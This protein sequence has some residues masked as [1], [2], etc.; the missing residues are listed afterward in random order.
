MTMH[1]E[2]GVNHS[3]HLKVYSDATFRSQV[4]PDGIYEFA[5]PQFVD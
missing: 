1:S 5:D 2:S 4:N 3:T